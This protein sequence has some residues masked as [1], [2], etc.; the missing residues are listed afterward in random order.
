MINPFK[1]INWKPDRDELKK[2]GVSLIIG[3]P[4]IA[5]VFFI[6]RWISGDGMPEPR[7]FLMLG[8]IGCAVGIVCWLISP[9]A[10]LLY[11][12]WYG[13]A[14]CVGIVLANLLFTL[15]FYVLFTPLALFMKLKGRDAL[16]LKKQKDVGSYWIDAPATPPA[17]QYFRQY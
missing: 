6:I 7:F 17:N 3:F 15:L 10:K 2:F 9:I 11:P 5:I 13:I 8:G 12:L 16:H 1:E 4:V 14:A